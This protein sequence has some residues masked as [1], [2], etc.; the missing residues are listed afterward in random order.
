MEHTFHYRVHKS[1]HEAELIHFTHTL[2]TLIR[3]VVI[4]VSAPT[5]LLDLVLLAGQLIPG[6]FHVY[7]RCVCIC[8]DVLKVLD[9]IHS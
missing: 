6:T 8:N 5:Y 7:L 4:L 1:P 2:F 9:D 3:V